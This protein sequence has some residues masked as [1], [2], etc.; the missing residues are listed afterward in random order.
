MNWFNLSFV[1]WLIVIVALSLV[2]Y[3]FDVAPFWIGIGAL[4]LG[5]RGEVVVVPRLR[6]VA[7][8]SGAHGI[9]R[10]EGWGTCAVRHNTRTRGSC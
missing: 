2:A 8:A 4:L 1:G 6:N 3:R 5:V 9:V 7:I 10:V